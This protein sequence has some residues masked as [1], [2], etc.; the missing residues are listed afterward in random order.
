MLLRRR[1]QNFKTS[2]AE[3]GFRSVNMGSAGDQEYP[4]DTA[5]GQ[6]FAGVLCLGGRGRNFGTIQNRKAG[7]VE[8]DHLGVACYPWS[9][10]ITL[11]SRKAGAEIQ[12]PAAALL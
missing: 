5:L 8:P 10:Y 6:Y 9:F 12:V 1:R 2:L 3:S 11:P 4:V 7:R